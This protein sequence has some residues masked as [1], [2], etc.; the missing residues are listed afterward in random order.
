MTIP[1]HHAARRRFGSAQD[2]SNMLG[3][4]RSTVYER[5]KNG[6]MPGVV[7]I[8]Y[9]VLFDLDKLERWLDAGGDAPSE[10]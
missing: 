9:R 5:A 2:V 8:G 10:A 3:L 4:P 6:N 1:T 7:R